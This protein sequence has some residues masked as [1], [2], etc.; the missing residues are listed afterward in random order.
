VTAKPP[1]EDG[2]EIE[3]AKPFVAMPTPEPFQDAQNKTI[4][5]DYIG[6]IVAWRV[7]HVMFPFDAAK[8]RLQ[9]L[10]AGGGQHAA[11]WSP[12]KR[13]AAFCQR[14]E[15]VPEATCSCGFYSA[16]D[17]QHLLSMSYH[18]GDDFDSIE[19]VLVIGEVG[20]SGKII[21]GTQG[22]RSQYARPLTVY[23][24]FARWKVA[25]NL[26]AAYPGVKVELRN[27]LY[28]PQA[29]LPDAPQKRTLPT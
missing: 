29:K 26:K 22:W 27:F 4:I 25:N 18:R 11:V 12:G 23:V 13:M 5:P 6:E 19:S 9:S 24:P 2:F 14:H 28:K 21:P 17:E 15:V 8:I 7:W 1:P 16:I 20:L 10:G 3:V